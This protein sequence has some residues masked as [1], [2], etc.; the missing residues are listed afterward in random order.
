MRGRRHSLAAVF[1]VVLGLAASRPG[2]DAGATDPGAFVSN[3]GARA[4]ETLTERGLSQPQRADRFRALLTTHFD[5]PGIGKFVLGR[6]WRGAAE[7]ERQEFLKLFEDFIVRTYIERFSTYS[8]EEYRVD[9]AREDENGYATVRGEILRPNA[10][11]VRVDWRMRRDGA[12]FKIIDM[13]VEGVSMALTQR[14][15]F[16]A[17]IRNGGGRVAA[18]NDVLRQRAAP[19]DNQSAAQ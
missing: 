16:A 6:Y 8:G 18:L 19:A 5:L 15:D 10:E 1:C 14:D 2:A 9:A 3:L 13:V 12:D 11:S 4:V 17:V 7:A